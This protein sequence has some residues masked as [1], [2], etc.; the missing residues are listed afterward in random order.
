MNFPRAAFFVLSQTCED[1]DSAQQVGKEGVRFGLRWSRD[2]SGVVREDRA[3]NYRSA[4][5]GG[6]G[7][8]AVERVD[9]K[10]DP[11]NPFGLGS[12]TGNPNRL[13]LVF[14]PGLTTN[15]ERIEL[16]VNERASERPDGRADLFYTSEAFRQVTFSAGQTRQVSG[17]YAHFISYRRLSDDR[18]DAVL[19]TAAYADPLQLERLFVTLGPSKPLIVFSHQLR[20]ERQPTSLL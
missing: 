12:N 6:L 20:L 16:F 19:V 2:A 17:E 14:A 4:V 5:R 10:D 1:R 18:V 11:N 13:K 15:A 3:Y 7:Y 8:D 9:Y